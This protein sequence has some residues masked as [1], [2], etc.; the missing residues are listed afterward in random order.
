MIDEFITHLID[1]IF[2]HQEDVNADEKLF[3]ESHWTK[4]IKYYEKNG[5]IFEIH[6][7]WDFYCNQYLHKH[8]QSIVRDFKNLLCLECGCGGGYESALMA[9]DGARVTILDYSKK[10]IEYAKIVSKQIGV[11]SKVEFINSDI[12]NFSSENKYDVTWNCGVIEHYQE[13]EIIK[14][15]NKMILNVKEKGSI[16][17]T[18]PNLISPQSIYWM[19][20]EGKG[21]ERYI[22][23]KKLIKLLKMLGLKNVYAR[24]M[25]YWLPSCF[26]YKWAI[27]I[28]KMSLVNKIRFLPWLFTVVGS[29]I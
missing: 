28:S 21:S 19:L 23:Q 11:M 4:M 18:V 25:N 20:K 27:K 22:S 24:T 6:N 1:N 8:Y 15:I 29:K 14:I 26:S 9:K 3:W 16:I 7:Q 10:A 5:E 2:P 12:L 13:N 17:I